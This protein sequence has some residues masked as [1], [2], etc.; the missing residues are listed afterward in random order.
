MEFD[1]LEFD[2]LEF[3]VLEFDVLE[4]DLLEFD[5]LEFDE[6]KF[7]VL[8]FVVFEFHV[9]ELD[10]LELSIGIIY[11]NALLLYRHNNSAER[12]GERAPSPT[13]RIT[14]EEYVGGAKRRG[15]FSS[16]E[17]KHTPSF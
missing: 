1:V 17:G 5:V 8:E 9:L 7:D 3:D 15:N 12:V 13:S 6:L 4:F 14:L 10:V 16:Q 2:A 11:C